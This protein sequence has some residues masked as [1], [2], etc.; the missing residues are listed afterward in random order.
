[1]FKL[2]FV[3]T[4]WKAVPRLGIIMLIM[5]VYSFLWHASL[6]HAL[7]DPCA[8]STISAGDKA[9]MCDPASDGNALSNSVA[10][11]GRLFQ[12][13]FDVLLVNK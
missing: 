12:H 2:S 5:L 3:E 6:T 4:G 1:M 13:A 7:A 9:R 11:P 10:A 8:S